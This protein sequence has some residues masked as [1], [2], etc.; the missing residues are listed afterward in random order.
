M[1]SIPDLPTCNTSSSLLNRCRRKLRTFVVGT[2]RYLEVLHHVIAEACYYLNSYMIKT[3]SRGTRIVLFE[4][5][6]RIYSIVSRIVQS[7][8]H[9]M[10][11]T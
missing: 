8:F 5:G 1:S 2:R 4:V 10:S 7:L 3:Q 11:G 9:Y 6:L